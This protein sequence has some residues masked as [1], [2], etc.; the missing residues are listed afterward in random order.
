[1]SRLTRESAARD[2]TLHFDL[3]QQLTSRLGQTLSAAALTIN[4]NR[5]QR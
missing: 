5:N 1:M 2:K 3:S 4:P